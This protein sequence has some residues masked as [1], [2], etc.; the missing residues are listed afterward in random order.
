MHCQSH[1]E[2]LVT[3]S[4]RTD[5]SHSER[6]IITATSTQNVPRTCMMHDPKQ[7]LLP[8]LRGSHWSRRG[9]S[10]AYQALTAADWVK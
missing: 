8:E 6:Q 4:L 2:L 9:V 7:A 10:T 5:G 1:H 3:A